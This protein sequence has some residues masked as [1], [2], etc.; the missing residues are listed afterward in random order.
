MAINTAVFSGNITQEPRKFGTEENPGLSFNI[1][2]NVPIR[3]N[4]AWTE[5]VMYVSCS[6]FGARCKSLAGILTKGMNVTVLGTL[7]PERYTNKDGVIVNTF[8][9]T[10]REIQLPPREKPAETNQPWA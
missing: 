7:K 3:E 1:A 5:D 2:V 10:A 8:G 9:M 6:M 4:G